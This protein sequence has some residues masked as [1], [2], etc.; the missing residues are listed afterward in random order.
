MLELLPNMEFFLE[1]IM[2][3]PPY[4][5]CKLLELSSL[6]CCSPMFLHLDFYRVQLLGKECGEGHNIS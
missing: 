1:I 2:T 4:L 3:A 5:S 6:L